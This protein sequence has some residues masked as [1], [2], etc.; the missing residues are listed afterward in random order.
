MSSKNSEAREKNSVIHFRG[1]KG[2]G[3]K[4]DQRVA[5]ETGFDYYLGKGEELEELKWLLGQIFKE[6]P[7]EIVT[8][9]FQ[10]GDMAGGEV[11]GVNYEDFPSLIKFLQDVQ[12]TTE[13]TRGQT[14]F[15]LDT[16]GVDFDSLPH[17]LE[18]IRNAMPDFEFKTVSS[19]GGA[20]ERFWGQCVKKTREL[21]ASRIEQLA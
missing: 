10:L 7:E 3:W 9:L 5:T 20:P 11:K 2:K 14:C 4:T 8:L 6:C 16:W 12:K 15:L 19:F 1:L 21:I 18:G 17:C 13:Q